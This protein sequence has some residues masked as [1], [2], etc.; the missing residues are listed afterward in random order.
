[1]T[2]DRSEPITIPIDQDRQVSGLLQVPVAATACFVFAHGAGAGMTHPFM[3]A[4]A[5][6]LAARKIATLRYQFPY[7]QV[8]SRRPDVPRVA[9][10]TVRAAVETAARQLPNLLLIAGGKSYGGR[11]T[12]QTQAEE[13]LPGVHGLAF[14]GFPLHPAKKPSASRAAH[15]ESVTVPML[16]LQGAR[17][18]LAEPQ[19]LEPLIRTLG[20]RATLCLLADADHSL[21]VLKRSGR[22][23]AQVMEAALD[24]MEDWSRRL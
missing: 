16:F 3:A 12:S 10:A 11:M 15:L 4:V 17:D 7:M 8:G 13:A 20:R 22:T 18:Q 9:H 23:D 2:D 6:G 24:A 14:F 19:Q 5:S 21:H 1:M